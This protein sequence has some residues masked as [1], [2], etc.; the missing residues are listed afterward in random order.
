MR[1]ETRQ[2][3][4]SRVLTCGFPQASGLPHTLPAAAKP[5]T[6]KVGLAQSATRAR[7]APDRDGREWRSIRNRPESAS[8]T[9]PRSRARRKR[10]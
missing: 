9:L 5:Y 1:P 8:V 7:P 6:P 3:V 4:R 10:V 2:A